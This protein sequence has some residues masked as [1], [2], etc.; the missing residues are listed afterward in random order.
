MSMCTVRIKEHAYTLTQ[1]ILQS[2]LQNIP[3]GI[4]K[5]VKYEVCGRNNGL[6]KAPL[7]ISFAVGLTH[8]PGKDLC[9]RSMSSMS[10]LIHT[11]V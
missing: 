1:N 3:S 8:T 9:L 2:N 5:S 10:E 7:I 6:P 4:V 11:L